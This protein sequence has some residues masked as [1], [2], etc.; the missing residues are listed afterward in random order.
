VFSLNIPQFDSIY[1]ENNNTFTY[2][3]NVVRHRLARYK[4][5][6]TSA[7]SNHVLNKILLLLVT[8]VAV[9]WPATI[10]Q[11]TTK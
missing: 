11:F 8:A 7:I 4:N 5:D 6:G 10:N 9:T 1:Q 3:T 2:V